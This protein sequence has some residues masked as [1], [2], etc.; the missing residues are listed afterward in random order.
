MR[1]W[2]K[3]RRKRWEEVEQWREDFKRDHPRCEFCLKPLGYGDLHELTPGS[4]RQ[5]ALDKP[6]AIL[7]VHRQCHD[8]LEMITI[9]NQ[10]AYLLRADEERFD[11]EA[12][13]R[14]IGRRWPSLEQVL[15][16]YERL[17]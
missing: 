4:S 15:F 6:Y 13:W 11:L 12:Y 3:K 7:H 16:F 10:L 14:L 8:V 2:S 5:K 9:P 17:P 1:Q